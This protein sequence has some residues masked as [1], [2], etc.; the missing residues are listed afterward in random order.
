MIKREELVAKGKPGTTSISSSTVEAARALALQ[1][2]AVIALLREMKRIDMQPR[3]ASKDL[4]LVR[5]E[6]MMRLLDETMRYLFSRQFSLSA[7]MQIE[8]ME[9]AES[10]DLYSHLSWLAWE[11]GLDF[12]F[13][14]PPRWEIGVEQHVIQLHANGYLTR[15][16]PLVVDANCGEMVWSRIEG[17]LT[18]SAIDKSLARA[19]YD[20]SL[21]HGERILD[22]LTAPSNSQSVSKRKLVEGDLAWWPGES[23]RLVVITNID[24]TSLKLWD[25]NEERGYS[26]DS[27]RTLAP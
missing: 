10:D 14:V 2:T 20:R 25:F 9:Y 3:W 12:R 24:P 11:L 4:C 27:V 6:S 8:D 16:M 13:P 18:P 17:S 23:D 21:L 5:R 1:L 7:K 26:V 22:V 19:W 15:L